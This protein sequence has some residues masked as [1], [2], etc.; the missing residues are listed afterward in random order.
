MMH[1]DISQHY[2]S[3]LD[4]GKE[5]PMILLFTKQCTEEVN[6]DVVEKTAD[7]KE[8]SPF[9][10]SVRNLEEK[11]EQSSPENEKQRVDTPNRTFLSFL[12]TLSPKKG[13]SL[14]PLLSP[15]RRPVTLPYEAPVS[16][17]VDKR[18]KDIKRGSRRLHSSLSLFSESQKR[19]YFFPEL[20]QH[21]IL[22]E[23]KASGGN[24][25]SRAEASRLNSGFTSEGLP[26]GPFP[27][28]FMKPVC[29]ADLINLIMCYQPYYGAH[30]V[31]LD[32]S[33]DKT[34]SGSFTYDSLMTRKQKYRNTSSFTRA[35]PESFVLGQET[36]PHSL[37]H[38]GLPR[39]S[40]RMDKISQD[41]RHQHSTS[42]EYNST[43]TSLLNES[44]EGI[45]SLSHS[46]DDD[47]EDQCTDI[48]SVSEQYSVKSQN[49]S[50]RF[51]A[52]GRE[53]NLPELK[54]TSRVINSA[55]NWSGRSDNSARS[56][57]KSFNPFTQQ[58]PTGRSDD[59]ARSTARKLY[60]SR[61]LSGKSLHSP[62]VD[63]KHADGLVLALHK[64]EGNAS[65]TKKNSTVAVAGK[66]PS[67]R[68]PKH[69]DVGYGEVFHINDHPETKS[70]HLERDPYGFGHPDSFEETFVEPDFPTQLKKGSPLN[71]E[72]H[73]TTQGKGEGPDATISRGRH[74][75]TVPRER[76]PLMVQ[77][78]SKSRICIIDTTTQTD[79]KGV[80]EAKIESSEDK[81]QD[82]LKLKEN[83][84][85]KPVVK[86]VKA[87]IESSED[88]TQ[89]ESRL[90]ENVK[91]KP[92][93]KDMK[94]SGEVLVVDDDKITVKMT[95]RMLSRKLF[96]VEVAENGRVG[97]EKMK[98]KIYRFVLMDWNM[99]VMD[100]LKCIERFREWEKGE[101]E[102]GTRK[103]K[104]NIVMFSAN[105]AEHFVQR[106]LEGG[107]DAFIAKPIKIKNILD[108]IS[109]VE[110]K[111]TE[112]SVEPQAIE[113]V[114]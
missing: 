89:H 42:G 60:S 14:L 68:S 53:I 83:V 96:S 37:Q 11:S 47:N 72:F 108:V 59:S 44:F 6:Q 25:S 36:S 28:I 80:N 114:G 109:S 106:A 13:Q 65:L 82:E 21:N 98:G 100:G 77:T 10:Q 9:H 46:I 93:V 105:A 58:N 78:K 30:V 20:P 5:P 81:S 102:Q 79:A 85:A 75:H 15:K 91:A 2:S 66:I 35:T 90:K 71:R 24:Y 103:S 54:I 101:M 4:P 92:A 33:I 18:E 39:G 64:R 113:K 50:R 22:D 57:L 76:K 19:D 38:L 112:K 16:T 74:T 26:T 51:S 61:V 3:K 49:S 67:K 110:A 73:Q 34:L 48:K 63:S 43:F 41:Y 86:D 29:D 23:M 52:R 84:K 111:Q 1:N 27:E 45:L 17:A 12:S 88:K 95:T 56:T 87:K 7:S 94:E 32:T 40:G 107:A 104:Q 99:P 69:Q 31:D 55:R 8:P 70:A 97:L 62:S